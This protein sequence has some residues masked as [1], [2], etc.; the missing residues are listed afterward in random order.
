VRCQRSAWALIGVAACTA[1]VACAQDSAQ[2]SRA[3]GAVTVEPTA[4]SAAPPATSTTIGAPAVP[5]TV[6]AS[7][8]VASTVVASTAPAGPASGDI[9]ITGF[10]YAYGGVPASVLAGSR[11]VFDNIS[12]TE[13]HEIVVW[14]L[15]AGETRG[16]KELMALP[17]EEWTFF[18][19]PPLAV[20]VAAPGEPGSLVEGL[21]DGTLELPGRYLFYCA[22]PTGLE[23]ARF[24]ELSAQSGG[25]VVIDG[26]P[27]HY[28]KGMVAELIVE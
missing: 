22:I 23:P 26:V 28:T 20:S 4:A 2:P 16:A 6:V 25:P 14:R 13:V 17:A 24:F 1:L 7:T 27:P 11:L 15:A 12:T 5:S 8:A 10:E 9:A 18:D 3:S 19:G 21:G